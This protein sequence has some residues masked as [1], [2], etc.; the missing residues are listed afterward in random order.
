[1]VKVLRDEDLRKKFRLTGIPSLPLKSTGNIVNDNS[2]R[3]DWESVVPKDKL[4]YIIGNPPFIGSRHFNDKNINDRDY[5][6]GSNCQSSYKRL[7]YI[8]L[9][10]LKAISYIQGTTVRV[11]FVTT[12]SITYGEY[13]NTF[14]NKLL[15]EK[16]LNCFL[17]FAY[18]PFKWDSDSFDKAGVNVSILGLQSYKPDICILYD[19]DGFLVT[20]D[21]LNYYLKFAETCFIERIKE[22]ISGY[23]ICHRADIVADNKYL[24]YYDNVEDLPEW[25]Q[26]Y[27]KNFI[28]ARS[29]ISRK[30]E[31]CYWLKDLDSDW[32]DEDIQERVQNVYLYRSKGAAT[33]QGRSNTPHLFSNKQELKKDII[34]IPLSQSIKDHLITGYADE[35]TYM[36]ESIVYIKGDRYLYG[37]LS[38]KLFQIW[39]SF[40]GGL[41]YGTIITTDPYAFNTFP[42]PKDIKDPELLKYSELRHNLLFDKYKDVNLNKLLKDAIP[43]DVR[44]C[45]DK[46]DRTVYRIYGFIHDDGSLYS[47]DE[48]LSSLLNMYKERVDSLNHQ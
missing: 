47:D 10:F 14:W 40:V 19:V 24:R 30:K 12:D 3:V 8:C 6:L 1:M 21:N 38:S 25:K 46:L 11:G 48:V 36:D 42:I 20:G 5:I 2:L 26:N 34:I 43:S 16:N 9:F 37:I 44:D 45:L 22:Q 17:Q 7:D 27:I 35:D 39:V 13:V 28:S 18:K 41:Q 32:W 15:T 29:F 31:Y 23:S 4:S 33:L